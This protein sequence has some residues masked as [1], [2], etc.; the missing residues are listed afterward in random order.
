MKEE[1]LLGHASELVRI[2][3]KSA[4]PGDA[5]ASEYFRSKKYIGAKDRRFISEWVFTTQRQLSLAEAYGK[6]HGIDDVVIACYTMNTATPLTKVRGAGGEE[7]GENDP[8]VVCTQPWLL[9]ETLKRWPD[10]AEVWRAMME[11]A[12]LGLRVNLRRVSREKVMEALRAEDIPCEAGQ[13]APAAI[14][15]HKRVNLTQHPLFKGGFFE[16]QDEGSQMISLACKVRPGMSVLDACAGAGG[17]T[18]HLADIMKDQGVIVARD[19]EWNRLREIPIRAHTAGVQCI[20]VDLTQSS[21]NSSSTPDTRSQRGP[22]PRISYSP[23]TTNYK[24]QTTFDVVLVDA[25]CSGMGTVRR[26]PMVK[27]RMRPDQLQRHVRKQQKI[28]ADNARYVAPGGALVYATCSILPAENEDVVND[29]L[30]HHP[31]FTLDEQRQMDPYHDGT[32]GLFYARLVRV[33]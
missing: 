16:I 12:P 22:K 4:Q 25:P 28:L 18:L 29:F 19:I 15:I 8:V 7:L 13:H 1:S 6:A 27:W 24:Q 3:R 2:I 9:D 32:D 20:R 33:S 30:Q 14:V 23:Q 10:A 21:G 26:L 31:E 17:K 11:P 5:I